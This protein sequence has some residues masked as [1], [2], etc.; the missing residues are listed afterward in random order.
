MPDTNA[1]A[2]ARPTLTQRRAMGPTSTSPAPV[3]AP[4]SM[5]TPAT[6]AGTTAQ[7][8]ITPTGLNRLGAMT[9]PPV[10]NIPS[11]GSPLDRPMRMGPAG[12]STPRGGVMP[13]GGAQDEKS[14]S[15]TKV[16]LLVIL[17]I[18]IAVA[19]YFAIRNNT[20]TGTP[21]V[22]VTPTPIV[23]ATPTPTPSIIGAKVLP[24]AEAVKA[25]V[26]TAYTAAAQQVGEVSN[27]VFTIDDIIGTK[28]TSF[29]RFEFVTTKASGP[30]E[31]AA[32]KVTAEYDATAL[33]LTLKFANTSTQ[34]DLMAIDDAVP[35][36]T[37][38]VSA[39][40]RVSAAL[41]TDDAY[42]INLKQGATY[43]LQILATDSPTIVVDVKEVLKPTVLPS[44]VTITPTPIVGN[45]ILEVAYSMNPQKLTNGLASNTADLVCRDKCFYWIETATGF[46]FEKP[47]DKGEDNRYP[48]VDAKL[49]G[50]RLTVTVTNLVT[51]NATSEITFTNSKLVNDLVATRKGNE[52][53]YEFALKS[54]KNYRVLFTTSEYLKTDVLRVQ[55][56]P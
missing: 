32:P 26:T 9:K 54:P 1:P 17:V 28:Y 35:V 15:P 31:V 36:D 25:P 48:N 16:I 22:T 23:T 21:K 11:G 8:G 24:D 56:K 7:G 51:K 38:T 13:P 43:F 12:A 5:A 39:L 4:A 19:S 40:T 46:T 49:D 34:A 47:V 44:G 6:P 33:M 30:D 14:G 20:D 3:E 2:P 29:T 27:A 41:A 18:G 55:V 42:Q 50:N 37:E 53:V 52:L 10:T 45:D